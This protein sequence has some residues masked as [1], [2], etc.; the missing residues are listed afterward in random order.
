MRLEE[1]FRRAGRDGKRYRGAPFWSWNDD[2]EP[3]ELRRQVREMKEQGLGGFFMHARVGLITPYLSERWMEC[4]EAAVDEARQLGLEAWL[5]DEDKWPSGTVGTVIPDLGPEWQQ[6]TVELAEVYA[7]QFEPQ[8]APVATFIGRR[9]GNTV[10]DVTYLPDHR[11]PSTVGDRTVFHF[12]VQTHGR[13]D[14]LKPAVVK[15]FMELTHEAYRRRVGAE[16]GKTIPGIFTDEPSFRHVPWTEGL[17]LFFRERNGYDLVENLLSVFYAAGDFHQVRYDFWS[18]V[19]DLYVENFTRRLHDWCAR[20]RLALT[21]H[22]LHEETLLSQLRRMGAAMQHY[23][24]LHMP[25]ID[26]LGRRIGD[27]LLCKQVSSVAHQFGGRRVLSETFGAV[28]WNLSFED[29]KW[30]GDWQYAQG[31]DRLCQ[32]LELYSMKGERKRDYPPSLYYQQ[33]WWPHNRVV[34][35]Y[36]ARLGAAL[37]SGKHRCDVLVLHPIGSAWAVHDPNDERPVMELSGQ[38]SRLS[39]FLLQI[40]RDYDYGDESIIERHGGVEGDSLRVGSARYRVVIVPPSVSLRTRVLDLLLR[41]AQAGGRIICVE[42]LPALEQGVASGRPAEQLRRVATIIQLDRDELRLALEGMVE[43]EIVVLEHDSAV[44]RALH[45]LGRHEEDAHT[46]FYQQREVGERQLFFLA[47]TDNHREVHAEVR[48]RGRGL[49]EE[50]DLRTGRVTPLPAHYAGS[51]TGVRVT[52][53]PA[54]SRLLA[55]NRA[56]EPLEGSAP[57]LRQVRRVAFEDQWQVQPR[58]HNA[59]T[60][61]YC[62]YR[63]GEGKWQPQVPTIWLHQVVRELTQPTALG[64]RFTFPMESDPAQARDCFLVVEQP[65]R[66]TITVNGHAPPPEHGWWTD[67]SWRKLD[68]AGLLRQGVNVVE[69][70]ASAGPELEVES[71]YVVGDFGVVRSG[72][73]WEGGAPMFA[74]VAAPTEVHTG[75]LGPQGYRF[76]RGSIAY[77]Q[78][79][80]VPLQAGQRAFLRLEGLE[81][82]LATVWVNGKQAGHLPWRPHE[83]EVTALLHRRRINSFEIELHGTCRN[84][85]GPHHNAAGDPVGVSPD[86]FLGGAQ[87][88][89]DPRSPDRIWRDHYSFVPFGI[90]RGAHVAIM[91]EARG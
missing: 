18:T 50:W 51:Y 59:L 41:F 66:Y 70:I 80:R 11:L 86:L 30:I 25:G 20:H 27:P 43:P 62:A 2:L 47:N 56:H 24:Y 67:I 29:Q 28:G 87:W 76:F 84:L 60:L 14:L 48:L 53:A 55:L 83:V 13:A 68:L 31:V 71:I 7:D 49:L 6:K 79:L 16:F 88:R 82:A 23:E 89:E 78:D 37:T 72:A 77:R 38:F 32:H 36:F 61:D 69:M 33:P 52:F 63:L 45:A 57:V 8:P 19:T 1:K 81:A 17:P 85:L 42:P 15:K 46:I 74:L 39:T 54:G 9:R 64:L 58:E 44:E 40:H 10:S 26:H 21:G 75:D 34:A 91:E 35:D 65:E 22:F 73:R 12:Y 90:T 4:I 3:E 5:Y